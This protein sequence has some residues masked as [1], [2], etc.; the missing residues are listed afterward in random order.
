MCLNTLLNL[1]RL[2]AVV[3]LQNQEPCFLDDLDLLDSFLD[4]L[5]AEKFVFLVDIDHIDVTLLIGSIELLLL[6]VPSEACE[7]SLV[8]VGKLIVCAALSLCSFEPL[9]SLVIRNC[10]D[11]V[12]LHDKKD[13]ND[14][15]PMNQSLFGIETE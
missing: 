10:E 13:L 8:R 14:A 4:Q 6:V 15:D 12:L 1:K 3:G 11:Q 7:H 5:L 9:K 2:K